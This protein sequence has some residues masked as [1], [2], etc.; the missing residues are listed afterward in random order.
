M[1]TVAAAKIIKQIGNDEDATDVANEYWHGIDA[2]DLGKALEQNHGWIVD[3]HV[4]EALD[5]MH[6][7]VSDLHKN[8]CTEWVAKYN[9][10]PSLAIGTE[11]KQ[12][13]ITGIS[14]HKPACYL[15][16]ETGCTNDNRSLI[17]K[18]EDAEAK[19]DHKEI[20]EVH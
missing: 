7:E 16:K 5:C 15:V 12:G 18:F 8:A 13:V 10:Q 20:S 17:I 6:F 2:Y 19:P 3:A 9:I 11:I 4:I 14:Q 1:V